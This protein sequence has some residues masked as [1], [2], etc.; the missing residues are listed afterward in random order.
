M[1]R[2]IGM[3]ALT[4]YVLNWT[5]FGRHLYATGDDPDAADLRQW[6][7]RNQRAYLE[8]TRRYLGWGVFV[9]KVR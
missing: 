5:R 2:L 9:L 7:I 6:H 4:W 8:Y 3:V 1:R